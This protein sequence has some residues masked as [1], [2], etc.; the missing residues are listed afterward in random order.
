[1]EILCLCWQ[2]ENY[3]SIVNFFGIFDVFFTF[4][5]CWLI[6][7][8]V[9]YTNL[10]NFLMMLF[11]K[12]R[13]NSLI[14]RYILVERIKPASLKRS[15][16]YF[17]PSVIKLKRVSA[18]PRCANKGGSRHIIKAWGDLQKWRVWSYTWTKEGANSFLS[19]K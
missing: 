10:T 19:S 18:H 9:T 7:S 6:L 14:S 1:M 5:K 12:K 11:F 3:S 13:K 2:S 15:K 4:S 16:L 8:T 17:A